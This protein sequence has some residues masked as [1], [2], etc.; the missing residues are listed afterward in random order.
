MKKGLVLEGGAMRGLFSAG[1][2]DVLMEHNIW[3]DGTIGVSAGAAFGCNMKSKQ[4][5]R[6]ISY[7]KKLAHDWRYASLR[8]LI[9]TGD[10]FGGEYAY[11]YIPFHV[12]PIDSETFRKNP[13][14]FWCVCTNVGSGKPHYQKLERVDYDC[15]EY[16]R[17]SASMPMF[18]KVVSIHG[19]R[20]LDGGIADSVPLRFFQEQGYEKNIV[21]LTQ[22]A[23][24]RKQSNKLMPLIRAWL[25]R[26]PKIIKALRERHI[27]YNGQ[28]DYV[29]AEEK[30][31][32]TFVICPKEPLT[33]GHISH[34]PQQMQATYD[35]GR[36]AAL[37]RIDDIKAFF[38]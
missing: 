13:M 27:V 28:L 22:P 37:E 15:L 21:V 31:G 8:S 6:V 5:G 17:A 4:P 1:V 36:Q 14:E 25:H 19:K 29:R 9:T 30:K 3:P 34:N 35:L 32:H 26:Y 20:F 2:I 18:A 10:Y 16:I 11:H 7:N 12:D 24:Y 38:L 33:I 23:N